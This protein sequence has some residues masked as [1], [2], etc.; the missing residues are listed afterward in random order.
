MQSSSYRP[1]IDGLRAVAVLM[2][3]LFHFRLVPYANAGFLGVDVFFVIS[4]FLITSIIVTGAQNGSFRLWTFYAKRVRRLAPAL[5]AT[6]AMIPHCRG[7]L[8]L[9]RRLPGT[10]DEPRPRLW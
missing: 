2:V 4:G 3:V 8:A 9:S 6:L 5:I 1:D 10:R 7:S